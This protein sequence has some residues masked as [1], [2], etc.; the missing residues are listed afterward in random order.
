MSESIMDF[1]KFMEKVAKKLQD[2]ILLEMRDNAAE[3][4]ARMGQATVR[5]ELRKAGIK[6]STET[7]THLGRSAKQRAS[8]ER[9]G[10]VLDTARKVAETT[11]SYSHDIAVRAGVKKERAHVGRF[12]DLGTNANRNNWGVDSGAPVPATNWMGK[13]RKLMDSSAPSVIKKALKKS[14]RKQVN[15]HGAKVLKKNGKR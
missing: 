6:R 15:I 7:G 10:S 9:Y 1:S 14:L 4:L 8:R 2:N 12:R 3:K 13:A 5:R 11:Q